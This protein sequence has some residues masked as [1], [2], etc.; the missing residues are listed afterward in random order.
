MM[1]AADCCGKTFLIILNVFVVLIGPLLL[2]G[3]L[4][5]KFGLPKLP[6][7][8]SVFERAGKSSPLE[9]HISGVTSVPASVSL[10][11]FGISDLKPTLNVATIIFIVLGVFMFVIGIVGCV[12][13]CCTVKALLAPYAAVV[14]LAFVVKVILLGIWL[15][16][17]LNGKILEFL[18]VAVK[19]KYAGPNAFNPESLLL[20]VIMIQLQC[21][22]IKNYT[23]FMGAAAWNRTYEY[24]SN[25]RTVVS[26]QKI[27]ITCCKRTG[28][29]QP[30]NDLNCTITP[31]A[32]NS[33]IDTGHTAKRLTEVFP[34]KNWTK[35]D[36]SKLLKSAGHRH[37]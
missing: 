14:L 36:V 11:D 20:N 4:F 21:C 35:H 10:D 26:Q 6:A 23:E 16:K 19:T 9:N 15:S 28:F 3:G 27:P 24:R 5:L 37:S 30:P 18:E 8:S 17:L 22:G 29:F 13:A 1:A 34:E 25:G 2:G 32:S 31:T 12:G 7:L 33:N